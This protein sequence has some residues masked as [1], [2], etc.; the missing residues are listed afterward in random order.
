MLLT[1]CSI[2]VP[3]PQSGVFYCEALGI[4]IDF[5]VHAEVGA[6]CAVQHDPEGN[7][8]PLLFFT[9][10]GW[11][12]CFYDE[13]TEESFYNGYGKWQ[14]SKDIFVID[15]YYTDNSYIFRLMEGPVCPYCDGKDA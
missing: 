6:G 7:C 15:E 14:K 9:D 4:S 8:R 10:Y 2:P 5:S 13:Q 11:G 3:R 12:V 1:G